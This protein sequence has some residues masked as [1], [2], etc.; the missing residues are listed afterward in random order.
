MEDRIPQ[1]AKELNHKRARRRT[2]HKVLAAAAC[3]VVFCTT[4]ALILPAITLE[5]TAY[6]GYEEHTMLYPDADLRARGGRAAPSAHGCVLSDGGCADLPA[7]G[8]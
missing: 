5:Q 8:A 6:C 4:Y 1:Q 7:A 3:V 2:W